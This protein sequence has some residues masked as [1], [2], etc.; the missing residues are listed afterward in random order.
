M[1]IENN[2]EYGY[3]LGEE[4]NA[5][6][7]KYFAW[8]E[9]VKEESKWVG[10][11]QTDE[12]CAALLKAYRKEIELLIAENEIAVKIRKAELEQIENRLVPKR[13]FW[14][15]WRKR[16]NRARDIVEDEATIYAARI[17]A[18]KE[19]RIAEAIKK[20]NE[21]EAE[22][23]N[24]NNNGFDEPQVAQEEQTGETAESGQPK[25]EDGNGQERRE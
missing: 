9:A 25:P 22:A 12:S 4:V 11:E 13:K 19:S 5:L 24:I 23:D 18:E 1:D 15:F 16:N 3:K 2:G 14:F 17:H 21:I 7:E 20:L 10:Q 8:Y 6:N